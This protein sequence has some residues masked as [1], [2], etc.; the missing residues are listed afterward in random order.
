M[1]EFEKKVSE[2]GLPAANRLYNDAPFMKYRLDLDEYISENFD[3]YEEKV[4]RYIFRKCFTNSKR[5]DSLWWT[6]GI[7]SISEKL[8]ISEQRLRK[9]VIPE[10][11]KKGFIRREKLHTRSY[12]TYIITLPEDFGRYDI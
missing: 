5:G 11:E 8:K 2:L 12:Y 4:F 1:G 9:T 10:L 7:N 6:E 3:V